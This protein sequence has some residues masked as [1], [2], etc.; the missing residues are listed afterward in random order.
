MRVAEVGRLRGPSPDGLRLEPRQRRPKLSLIAAGLLVVVGF[1]LAGA[2]LL[3]RVA[4]RQPVLALA[5]PIEAGEVLSAGHLMTV[6]VGTDDGVRLVA[7]ADREE[8]VGRVATASLPAGTLVAAEQ[9]SAGPT[10]GEGQSVVGLALEP[11]AYPMASLRPGTRVAVVLTSDPTAAPDSAS[12]VDG[13]LAW[14]VE[15]AEVFAVEPLG[16]TSRT[17]LVSVTVDQRAAPKI[18]SAA[19][20]DRVR[21]VLVP[22]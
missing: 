12:G 11:G 13:P 17:L 7:A 14:G 9:F 21:L 22:R 19:A 8:L 4:D 16:E 18:A 5:L 3:A 15:Q 6:R 10:V 20:A 2:V 1:G